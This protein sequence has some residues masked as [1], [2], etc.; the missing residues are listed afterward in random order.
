[1]NNRKIYLPTLKKLK[2]V[3]F[4]LYNEDIEYDFIDGINLIIGGNGVGKTTFINIIKYALIGL[5]KKDL[6]VRNYNGEKRFFRGT[7]TNCNIYF[8]SRMKEGEKREDSYVELEFLIKDTLI[9]VKRSLYNIEILEASYN[10]NGITKII[11]GKV[12]RQDYYSKYENVENEEKQIYL[13]YKYEELV[14]KKVNLSD[15][16]DFIFFVGQILLFGETRENILWAEDLQNRLLSNYFNDPELEK[17]RKSYNYEAKYQDSIARHRQEEIKAITKV[18]KKLDEKEGNFNEQ[19]EKGQLVSF[20]TG[21]ENKLKKIEINIETIQKKNNLIFKQISTIS[22]EISE[23]EQI[24]T[25]LE[26]DHNKQFW[27]GANSKYNIYK[28]QLFSNHICPMCN[29]PIKNPEFFKDELAECFLCHSVITNNSTNN[30]EIDKIKEEIYQ[31]LEE[32]KKV[33]E[34]SLNYEEETKKLDIERMKT[35]VE[36]FKRRNEL[37]VINNKN[38]KNSTE[39]EESYIAMKTRIEELDI[40]KVNATTNSEKYEKMATEIMNEIEEN[41]LESTKNISTIFSDF[42]EAF[43]KVECFLTFDYGI[44]KNKIFLPVIDGILRNDS[45]ELSESQ[46]FF[47]D[48]SFRMSILSFFYSCP[49]FYICETPDSSLDLSYEEN[50]AN[51]FIKFLEKPNSLILT[52]NLNNSTFINCLINKTQKI[53]LLNLLKVGKISGVQSNHKDLLKLSNEIEEL[54]NGSIS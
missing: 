15:F 12:I 14:A 9:K 16:N 52:S 32:R 10:E 3:N 43:L 17:Q 11:E 18:I 48:Y 28:N 51:T 23:K 38:M 27:Q 6:T 54:I 4:S 20:I 37:R 34:S 41:L 25:R 21:L 40:E 13:Q 24:K 46:R 30:G 35:R 45:E 26:L 49:S 39:N 22:K 53:K 44:N 2:I 19:E 47:V 33:E 29:K 50:A 8:R 1:M 36:L 5:Y 7:Y 31:L 42:A